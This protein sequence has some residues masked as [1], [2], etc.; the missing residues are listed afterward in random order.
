MQRENVEDLRGG[1]EKCGGSPFGL[2][3]FGKI[4]YEFPTS[5]LL[6][7]IAQLSII[8]EILIYKFRRLRLSVLL[9]FVNAYLVQKC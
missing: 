1:V 5:K 7:N 4:M 6:S 9:F 3:K 8:Y 2:V